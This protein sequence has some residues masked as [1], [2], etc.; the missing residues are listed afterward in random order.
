MWATSGSMNAPSGLIVRGSVA[1]VWYKSK[2]D[3]FISEI[4]DLMLFR[5]GVRVPTNVD[6]RYLSLSL[7]GCFPSLQYVPEVSG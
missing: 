5:C 3:V 6:A 2:T 1:F 7:V 4:A